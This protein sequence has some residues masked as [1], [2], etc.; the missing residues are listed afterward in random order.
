MS[1]SPKKDCCRKDNAMK[2]GFFRRVSDGR[3][4]QRYRCKTCNK[5][6]SQ[7]TSDPAYYQ[8]KRQFNHKCMMMLGSAMSQRRVA[9]V[10]GLH[11]IT[12]ARK[13]VFTAGQSKKKLRESLADCS[14]V[15]AIQ[16]DEL[17]TIEHTKCKPL[18]VALAVAEDSRK[19]VGFR[20]SQMPAT[21]HL[22]AISRKKYGYRKDERLEG[23]Y[24]LFEELSEKLNSKIIIRSDE[25][26]YYKSVVN[27]CFPD[28]K[29]EQFKGQKSAISGQGELKKIKRDPLFTI[30]H[31][32]AMLR[33]NI[34]RLVRKTWCT[35]K[36]VARLVDH[37]WLYMWVHNSR[38]TAPV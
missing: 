15:K 31:T 9:L 24:S 21:G 6:F 22:A 1:H 13:L 25:C 18:S 8:K 10:L 30:N 27:S 16:F 7:A 11:P 19:I 33:A 36:K 37:L 3:T 5:T 35:T 20:V 17:Q 28:S 34:N 12:V 4:L 26:S 2:S 32:F 38:L 23:M 29:H 14:F